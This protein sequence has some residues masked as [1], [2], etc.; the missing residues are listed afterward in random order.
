MKNAFA[1]YKISF[2]KLDASTGLGINEIYDMI[3]GPNKMI[4]LNIPEIMKKVFK[5]SKEG[6]VISYSSR[7][8]QNR[9]LKSHSWYG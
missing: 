6:V 3:L 8:N 9:T 2:P 5:Y 1:K 7:H 4:C